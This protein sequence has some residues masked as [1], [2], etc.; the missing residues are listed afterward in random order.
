MS[1]STQT[2]TRSTTSRKPLSTGKTSRKAAGLTKKSRAARAVKNLNTENITNYT[3]AMRWLT[4]HVDF[5][6]MRIVPSQ[7]RVMS[8]DRV[9][10]LL[11]QLGNPQEELKCVQVAGTKGKGSTCAM[12]SHMLR[13]CGYTVGLYSSPHLV[14]L[15][16]RITIDG[17]MISHADLTDL[18]KQISAKEKSFKGNLPTFF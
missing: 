7:A 13:A 15:R 12:I 2:K 1:L 3:S 8:L 5:E 14:D 6:R 10:K 17:A 16:E 9:K 4:D 11:K 18:L